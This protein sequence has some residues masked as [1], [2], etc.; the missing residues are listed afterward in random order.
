MADAVLTPEERDALA[1]E[2]ALGVLDGEARAAALRSLMADPSF[3]PEMIAA[4]DRR[5]AAFHDAYI[6]VMPPETLWPGIESRIADALPTHPAVGQLRWWR[7]G[8]L[9]S[10]AIAA[11][12]ALVMIVR[13]VA[14]VPVAQPAQVAVAQMVGGDD[15]P[16]I[17]ARYDPAS[18]GL[19][20]RATGV[21]PDRL[22]PE[23]W[24]IPADGKARSLG[25]IADGAESRVA[26][27]PAYRRFMAEGTTLAVTME[28]ID[29]A[30]H[31]A[32]SSAP[33]AA[34]KISIF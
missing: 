7:A 5:L 2:M 20:L 3:S 23:L 24:I 15:G 9:A 25:L 13:P 6:P 28:A 29:G 21:T 16:M 22:A 33:I 31:D 19:V 1:A 4:W 10:A 27:A 14:P 34:G 26:V 18:G 11:S 30:P 12:L 8:A 17:L 32:P